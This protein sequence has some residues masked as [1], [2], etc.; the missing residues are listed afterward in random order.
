MRSWKSL[1][2]TFYGKQQAAEIGNVWSNF[3]VKTN[4]KPPFLVNY[5]K[6]SSVLVSAWHS[7]KG[8]THFYPFNKDFFSLFFCRA[9][10]LKGT[11]AKLYIESWMNDWN[12]KEKWMENKADGKW[13]EMKTDLI[14]FICHLKT[15]RCLR[16]RH[17]LR[18]KMWGKKSRENSWKVDMMTLTSFWSKKFY[19][20]GR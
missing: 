12:V 11:C 16:E 7:M 6:I 5:T 3:V 9:R 1:L 4:K 10:K 2:S 19:V 17:C 14:L 13:M 15:M 18:R 8:K 20:H